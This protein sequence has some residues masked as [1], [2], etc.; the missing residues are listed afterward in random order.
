VT[1]DL[2]L[3]QPS[4]RRKTEASYDRVVRFASL[5]LGGVGF[6][7]FAAQVLS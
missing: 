7:V 6:A 1:C 4:V 2:A 3:G 5:S